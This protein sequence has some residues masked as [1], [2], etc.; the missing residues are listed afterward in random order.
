MTT[1]KEEFARL[2]EVEGAAIEHWKANPNACDAVIQAKEA[3]NDLLR[4]YKRAGCP[5]HDA[6]MPS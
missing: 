3:T 5:A 1:W 6:K 4:K 2:S